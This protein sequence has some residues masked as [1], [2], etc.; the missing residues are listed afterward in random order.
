[1]SAISGIL[2]SQYS[3]DMTKKDYSGQEQE[4]SIHI[5]CK[6]YFSVAENNFRDFLSPGAFVVKKDIFYPTDQEIPSKSFNN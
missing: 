2:K 4:Y 3:L 1:M 5:K 6:N